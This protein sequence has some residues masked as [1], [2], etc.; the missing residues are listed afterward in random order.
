MPTEISYKVGDALSPVGCLP[1]PRIIAHICNDVG[2]FGAGFAK[3]I[4]ER[5]PRAKKRY[6]EQSKLG[7]ELGKVIFVPVSDWTVVA[8]MVAQHGLRG[9]SDR[10]PIRYDALRIA[11]THVARYATDEHSVHM[12]AIGTGLAGGSWTLIAGIIRITLCANDVPVS[13]YSP[14]SH[15]LASLINED[16]QAGED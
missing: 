1:I 12:P 15:T 7:L 4:A 10:P 2:V 6:L 8:N 5:Y 13:V 3:Q 11:L 9:Q 14:T 16:E